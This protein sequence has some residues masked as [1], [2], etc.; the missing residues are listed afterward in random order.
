MEREPQSRKMAPEQIALAAALALTAEVALS[1]P[2]AADEKKPV[3]QSVYTMDRK[4]YDERAAQI[5]KELA[6]YEANNQIRRVASANPSSVNPSVQYHHGGPNATVE[7]L[8]SSVIGIA[9]DTVSSIGRNIWAHPQFLALIVAIR[10]VR[11]R[12]WNGA[13]W[14]WNNWII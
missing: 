7:H 14:V 13:V 9:A 4:A 5:E 3:S 2:I 12:I 6:E 1:Q 10:P 11:T 8:V